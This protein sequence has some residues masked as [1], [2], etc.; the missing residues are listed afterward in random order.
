MAKKDEVPRSIEIRISKEELYADICKLMEDMS[1]IRFECINTKD[2]NEKNIREYLQLAGFLWQCIR[3]VADKDMMSQLELLV[4]AMN[5]H[6]ALVHFDPIQRR[7]WEKNCPDFVARL[8]SALIQIYGS[9]FDSLDRA[10]HLVSAVKTACAK[11]EK[12]AEKDATTEQQK[13]KHA[14]EHE[15]I[16]SSIIPV[17]G[18]V[19][20]VDP[21]TLFAAE[22]LRS[23]AQADPDDVQANLTIKMG[24]HCD[25]IRNAMVV[26]RDLGFLTFDA[27]VSRDD[28]EKLRQEFPDMIPART[29]KRQGQQYI[30]LRITVNKA[31]AESE[32]KQVSQR[33][34]EFVQ[35]PQLVELA[36][37]Y[38]PDDIGKVMFG[39][40]PSEVRKKAASRFTRRFPIV[41]GSA[42]GEDGS[43]SGLDKEIGAI[44]RT[45]FSYPDIYGYAIGDEVEM[46]E[47]VKEDDGNDER[48]WCGSSGVIKGISPS[49]SIEFYKPV[50]KGRKGTK[51]HAIIWDVEPKYLEKTG[52]STTRFQKWYKGRQLSVG[53]VVRVNGTY[54]DDFEI[55]KGDLDVGSEGKVIGLTYKVRFGRLVNNRRKV[56]DGV[57]EEVDEIN[58]SYLT[59]TS[60]TSRDHVKSLVDKIISESI[61][62]ALSSATPDIELDIHRGENT[63]GYV[64]HETIGEYDKCSMFFSTN[65]YRF[66]L[67]YV[68]ER[69]EEKEK[70]LK[71][72]MRKALETLG[73]AEKKKTKDRVSDEMMMDFISEYKGLSRDAFEK[74]ASALN[75]IYVCL[76]KFQD[77][78]QV[79]FFEGRR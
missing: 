25:M 47:R 13:K 68:T 51:G 30:T 16:I 17:I 54:A 19:R 63:T 65:G 42:I 34:K 64:H 52:N 48:Y 7:Y 10:H 31:P 66:I 3:G 35:N 57:N 69:A 79:D 73:M 76:Y 72:K 29:T 8:D 49:V 6:E 26:A 74:I 75:P 21:V 44:A 55:E 62:A 59:R 12:K 27:E 28:Y 23:Y 36:E 1:K 41:D 77:G 60:K 67:T 22:H 71:A 2:L 37:N 56:K 38:S 18:R 53:D 9:H 78:N 32:S 4:N 45:I 33:F 24:S 46:N 15:R 39:L 40:D 5:E 61:K 11:N 50:I 58:H 70:G 20:G 14:A 43:I